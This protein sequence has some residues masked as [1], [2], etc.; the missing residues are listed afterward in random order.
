[1]RNGSRAGRPRKPTAVHRLAG[2]FRPD[3]H[4]GD[5]P[6]PAAS[7]GRAPETLTEAERAVWVRVSK[8]LRAVGLLTVAD[9]D[10]LARYCEATVEYEMAR[11]ELLDHGVVVTFGGQTIRSPWIGIRDVARKTM[12]DLMREFGMTPAS[13]P[14]LGRPARGDGDAPDGATRQQPDNDL[15]KWRREFSHLN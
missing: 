6:T 10:A 14:R 3:R 9:R 2:T 13:R 12:L 8:T 4:G 1:M 7:T 11:R 15:E 5:E